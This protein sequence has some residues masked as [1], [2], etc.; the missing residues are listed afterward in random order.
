MDIRVLAELT[1]LDVLNKCEYK[2]TINEFYKIRN[3]EYYCLVNDKKISDTDD[4]WDM[5]DSYLGS[6]LNVD[7]G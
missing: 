2:L 4:N 5:F 3:T 6:M 7:W 1:A